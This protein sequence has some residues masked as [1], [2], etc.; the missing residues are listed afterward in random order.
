MKIKTTDELVREKLTA[1]AKA[2]HYYA[3]ALA[4]GDARVARRC[5][6]SHNTYLREIRI[7]W[8]MEALMR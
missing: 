2:R 4:K 1:A 5:K 7:L 8:E 3:M 6:C